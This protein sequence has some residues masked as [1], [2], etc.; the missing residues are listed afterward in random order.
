MAEQNTR[1]HGPRGPHGGMA[2]GEKAKDFKGTMKKL[3]TYIGKYKFAVAT[4]IVFAIGS[5]IFS[6]CIENG[7][8]KRRRTSI[9]CHCNRRTLSIPEGELVLYRSK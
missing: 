2:P 9:L 7:F 8:I 6:Q 5:T 1:R 3:M 4:V